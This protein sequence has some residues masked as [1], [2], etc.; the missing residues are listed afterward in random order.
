MCNSSVSEYI[1][2]S[3]TSS[4]QWRLAISKSTPTTSYG[5]TRLSTFGE[6]HEH[7]TEYIVTNAG[8]DS[9]PTDNAPT[10]DPG[11]RDGNAT[12]LCMNTPSGP[13]V[14]D[15]VSCVIDRAQLALTCSGFFA[16]AATYMTLTFNGGRFSPLILLLL[17]HQSLLDMV[18]CGMGSLYIFLPT[19]YWLTGSRIVD[20]IVCHVWHSQIIYW[21]C[22]FIG[23][24]NLVLIGVERFIM[25]CKPFVY[26]SVTRKHVLCSFAVL[27][28][29]CLVSLSPYYLHVHFVDGECSIRFFTEGF[30]SYFYKCYGFFIL[31]AFYILPVVAFVLLYGYV[32]YT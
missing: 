6:I 9:D 22:V 20:V 32:A 2:V 21:T 28:I 27:H 7:T 24:W 5:S 13:G 10:V 16:N 11:C 8:N 1:G 23:A 15:D 26:L 25:I 3:N 12:H 18:A 30:W 19:G 4:D 31:F 29:G 17:K 14:P